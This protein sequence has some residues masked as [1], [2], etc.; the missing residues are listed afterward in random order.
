MTSEITVEELL[1]LQS[2]TALEAAVKYTLAQSHGARAE[3][4]RKALDFACNE[5][6]VNKHLK[7]DLSEDQLT[8]EVC[9]FMNGLG[10]QPRH[11]EQVGGHCD[12]VVRGKDMFIWLAEAKWHDAYAWLDKG[13][14]QLSDR[15]STGVDGQDQGEVVIYCKNSDAASMLDRWRKELLD[16]NEGVTTSDD[17][18]GARLV[19]WSEHLHSAS[20]LP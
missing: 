14:K 18:N 11:D 9:Q 7:Q 8:I 6:E 13:F 1:K 4:V 17:A 15:Y 10:F 20:G 19:F 16:R 12:I 5:L 2:G 3:A